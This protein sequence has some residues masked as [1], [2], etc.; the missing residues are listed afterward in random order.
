MHAIVRRGA[1][2]AHLCCCILSGWV[3]ESQFGRQLFQYKLDKE[4]HWFTVSQSLQICITL[5]AGTFKHHDLGNL[6]NVISVTN[7]EENSSAVGSRV[8]S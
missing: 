4:M 5:T 7:I 2:A 8:S 6:Q 1:D 3:E